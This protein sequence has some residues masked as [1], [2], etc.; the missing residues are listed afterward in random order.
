MYIYN[1]KSTRPVE[2]ARDLAY[3]SWVDTGLAVDTQAEAVLREREKWKYS[4]YKSHFARLSCFSQ[5]NSVKTPE[6]KPS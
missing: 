3:Y 1:R 6:I 2:I 4:F 5:I